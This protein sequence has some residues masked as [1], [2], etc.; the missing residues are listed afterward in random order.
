MW[1][2]YTGKSLEQALTRDELAKISNASRANKLTPKKV[3]EDAAV[4]AVGI[5]RS[6][7]G[8]RYELGETGTIPSSARKAA[9]AIS[10]D[11]IFTR[12]PKIDL[13]SDERKNELRDM[14]AWL[15]R[16]ASGDVSLDDDIGGGLPGPSIEP[17]KQ[18]HRIY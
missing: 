10:R 6:Y 7:V 16:V 12:L 9:N 18:T 4:N 13:Y 17:R 11:S 14:Y 3:I 8:K 15:A 1:V 2:Q 5:V